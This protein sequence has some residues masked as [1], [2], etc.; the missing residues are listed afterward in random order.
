MSKQLGRLFSTKPS[1]VL[2][3]VA[4]VTV[5]GIGVWIVVSASNVT[6]SRVSSST[7]PSV[8]PTY[9]GLAAIDTGRHTLNGTQPCSPNTPDR[10]APDVF[11]R[12]TVP[13]HPDQRL[14]TEQSSCLGMTRSDLTFWMRYVSSTP[15]DEVHTNRVLVVDAESPYLGTL[16]VCWRGSAPTTPDTNIDHWVDTL[17]Q[18]QHSPASIL[19][20]DETGQAY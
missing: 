9:I 13:A 7:A 12:S 19:C 5:F 2:V 1:R 16:H 14:W 3:A 20:L 17:D 8:R 11:V 4:L 15:A 18:A 10:T 6:P